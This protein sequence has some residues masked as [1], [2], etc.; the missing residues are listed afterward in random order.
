VAVSRLN[1]RTV[2]LE[3]VAILIARDVRSPFRT[4]RHRS[5]IN[6][7]WTRD[8]DLRLKPFRTN[9]HEAVMRETASFVLQPYQAAE[10]PIIYGS[11]ARSAEPQLTAVSSSFGT[12]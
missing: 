8:S 6:F 5:V 11:R 1:L 2:Y 12:A 7:R 10:Q 3:S 4:R 9:S